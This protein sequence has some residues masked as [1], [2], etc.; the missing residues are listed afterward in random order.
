MFQPIDR[1]LRGL[2]LGRIERVVERVYRHYGPAGI[3]ARTWPTGSTA[4][5]VAILLALYLLL[6]YVV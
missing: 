1:S 5:W 4:L 3:M 2:T 6:N